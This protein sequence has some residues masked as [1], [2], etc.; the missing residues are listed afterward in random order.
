MR[1][2]ADVGGFDLID[3]KRCTVDFEATAA[4]RDAAGTRRMLRCADSY[5]IFTLVEKRAT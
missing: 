1:F 3:C 2:S 5:D 4:A